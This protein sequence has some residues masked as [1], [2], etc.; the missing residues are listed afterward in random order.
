MVDGWYGELPFYLALVFDDEVVT[1]DLEQ[2]QW[3]ATYADYMRKPGVWILR[4]KS[5][6]DILAV[7]VHDGDQPYYTARHVGVMGNAGSNE[8]VAHGIGKK[9]ADGVVERLWLL[10]NGVVCAGDDVG[11]LGIRLVHQLGPR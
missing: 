5:G 9:R 1:I 10:P 7:V 3:I 11:D 2:P 8:V 4:H 6:I